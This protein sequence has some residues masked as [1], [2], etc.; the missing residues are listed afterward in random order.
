[1]EEELYYVFYV[2]SGYSV[3]FLENNMVTP[4]STFATFTTAQF[5]ED[6]VTMLRTYYELN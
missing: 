1:M 3:P 5:I 2:S 6:L 4:D